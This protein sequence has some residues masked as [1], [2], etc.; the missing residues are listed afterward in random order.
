MKNV[1]I[2]AYFIQCL[3]WCKKTPY[4]HSIITI[5]ITPKIIFH[6]TFTN[7]KNKTTNYDVANKNDDSNNRDSTKESVKQV[8]FENFQVNALIGGFDRLQNMKIT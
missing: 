1:K 6:N 7:I 5:I 3:D 4:I 8:S 2:A